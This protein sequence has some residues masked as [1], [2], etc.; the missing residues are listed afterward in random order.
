MSRLLVVGLAPL[1]FENTKKNFGPGTRTWQFASGLAARGHA[2]DL[3]AIAIPGV[4]EEG[5]LVESEERDGVRIVRWPE[6]RFGDAAGVA[7]RLSEQRYGAVVGATMYG[8]NLLAQCR[9]EVPFWADQFGHVMA[10]AQVKAGVEQE[11]W[12]LA[13]FWRIVREIDA[14]AD[15]ISTVSRKQRLA[16]MGELGAV[17][18]L[19]AKTCGHEL[20]EVVPCALMQ[21]RLAPAGREIDLRAGRVP[22]DAFVLLW[23]GSFNTWSDVETL[24]AGVEAAMEEESRIW[25]CS[26]GGQLD[27]H[28][29]VTYPRFC[30]LVAASRHRERFLLEG[31]VDGELVAD[32]VDQADLGVLTE[33]AIYEGE[34]G[35]KNRI[36][37]WMAASLPVAYNRVGD[38]GDDLDRYRLGLTFGVGD[39]EAFAQQVLWAARH[40][41]ELAQMTD[42]AREFAQRHYSVESS[43]SPLALWCLEP[44]F[45]PDREERR[46]LLGSFD[47]LVF[48]GAAGKVAQAV[49]SLPIPNA[50]GVR[51]SL[52][53]MARRLG[54]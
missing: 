5:S 27:G 53:R 44:Q 14:T 25:F 23:S 39:A 49:E 21:E 24:F 41:E 30:E 31:W 11:N 9:P 47:P 3:I 16:C 29:E 45:A 51:R 7:Q 17:G 42:R 8:S 26:T 4:Y 48:E 52:G 43:I 22:D 40:P 34:L 1:P 20:V 37:E 33:K 6:S 46:A 50:G 36:A 19:N 35:S 54:F 32:Y 2:V 38:I 12:P 15:R 28:D 13:Y 18:R 10:E